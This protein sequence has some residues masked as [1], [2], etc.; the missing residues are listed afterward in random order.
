MF[1]ITTGELM[2]I[3]VT[4]LF[5]IAHFTYLVLSTP[6]TRKVAECP[7]NCDRRSISCPR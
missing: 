6:D 3:G 4:T 1:H 7:C 5:L 2:F